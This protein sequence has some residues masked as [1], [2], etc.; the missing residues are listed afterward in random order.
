MSSNCCK[1]KK[2]KTFDHLTF[3]FL[4]WQRAGVL[5]LSELHGKNSGDICSK[6]DM[7]QTTMTSTEIEKFTGDWLQKWKVKDMEIILDRHDTIVAK[8]KNS[9]KSYKKG[10][11]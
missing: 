3:I 11:W 8:N 7:I 4:K 2:L 9:T 1:P 10:K 5:N 6:L